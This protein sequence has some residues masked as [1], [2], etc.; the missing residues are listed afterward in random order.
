MYLRAA[1]DNSWLSA[2]DAAVLPVTSAELPHLPSLIVLVRRACPIASL[3]RA[4]PPDAGA[5]DH[6]VTWHRRILDLT[7]VDLHRGRLWQ[8]LAGADGS[9]ITYQPPTTAPARSRP[10]AKSPK[11]RRIEDDDSDDAASPPPPR[12]GTPPWLPTQGQRCIEVRQHIYNENRGN[13]KRN[14]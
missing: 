4:P 6:A 7:P 12:K 14:V 3:T 10:S 5:F 2:S 9:N 8:F 11:R 13:C 1:D